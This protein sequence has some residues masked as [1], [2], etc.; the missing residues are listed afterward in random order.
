[1]RRDPLLFVTAGGGAALV[2]WLLLDVGGATAQLRLFWTVVPV[3]DLLLW[4][5]AR[6]VARLPGAP[7]GVRRFWREC[8]RAALVFAAGDTSQAVVAWTRPGPE[9]AVANSFQASCILLGMCWLI[10]VTLTH[11][12]PIRSRQA[13]IRFWLDAVSVLVGA[14]VL[15]WLLVLPHGD[16]APGGALVALLLGS[17]IILFA[18]FAAVKL[19]LSGNA[20]IA[21]RAATPM[22]LAG[23]IQGLV[24]GLVTADSRHLGLLLAAQMLSVVL[25]ASGPRLQERA[26]LAGA[27]PAVWRA[28]PYSL[29]PYTTLAGMFAA[30]P[31]VLRDGLG[32]DAWLL[33]GGLFVATV[34]AVS[35]Q[36]LAFAEN[37]E[38]LAQ[39][40]NQQE[41]FQ[42]LLAYSTDITSVV[43]AGGFLT[44]V[45]PA[46]ERL[47]G[48]APAAVL[49]TQVV[50]HVHP[51]DLPAF[52]AALT[53]LRGVADATVSYQVRYA[54]AD[55]SWRWLDVV[56]R[57][58]LHVPSV[59]GYVSNA[60]DATQARLLQDELRH[61]A[62]HDGLTGLAN[63]ALFDERLTSAADAGMAAVL[64][65]DLND[66]KSINDT[67]GHH[68]GDV[69]LAGVAE[70]LRASTPPGGT[71]ARIGGDEFAVVLPGLDV[72]GAAQVARRFLSL[73]DEPMPVPGQRIPVR[74]SVGIV[75]GDPRDAE[76][77]LQRADAEM[78]RAKREAR[79]LRLLSV[80]QMSSSS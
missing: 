57:N 10:W 20:P 59:R 70:R 12:T 76:R 74:A 75:D 4:Y 29:L 13:R 30:V 46:T 9:T 58:L 15:V 11:P 49:G 41:H 43:D 34:L 17:V 39:L 24:G 50:S 78:Y 31:L 38:L 52:L 51:D 25:V 2:G 48:K 42:S 61:Q 6:R 33:L 23:A 37:A 19:I 18:A 53:R 64:L 27:R 77:L 40:G 55:G 65:V 45:S 56:S 36:L 7:A 28:R 66:F 14:G 79:A 5:F 67:H 72:I 32:P 63:R 26:M 8:G 73:L 62:T 21:R 1:M 35:R 60:R 68:V 80:P 3:F 22:L 69:V 44:Y 16:G 47:L 71:A 54:H